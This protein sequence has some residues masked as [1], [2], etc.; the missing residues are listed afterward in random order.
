MGAGPLIIT[1]K[2]LYN[3]N[4]CYIYIYIIYI[5]ISFF[6]YVLDVSKT[7]QEFLGIS[8]VWGHGLT[9]LYIYIISVYIYKYIHRSKE[10]HIANFRVMDE[11]PWSVFASSCILGNGHGS[12]W[13][14]EI[15]AREACTFVAE[16]MTARDP[17]GPR[18]RKPGQIRG[19]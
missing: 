14:H 17:G 9:R 7:L 11:S 19:S 6:F 10:V 1:N 5:Y 12:K 18:S 13:T 4:Y 2:W 15:A 16:R 3:V 8:S